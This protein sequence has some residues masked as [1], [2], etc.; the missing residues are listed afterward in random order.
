MKDSFKKWLIAN[1]RP[2]RYAKTIITISNDLKKVGYK[3]FDLYSVSNSHIVK[4]IKKDYFDIEEYFSKNIRGN[5]MYSSAFDRYIEFLSDE[6]S[7]DII[8]Y[9]DEIKEERL[10]E[11]SKKQITVNAYERN[12]KA[13]EKCIKHYGTKCFICSF[14]FEKTY[15][16]IGKGFI[17]V[18]HLKPLSEINEEYT[19]DPIEDLRP[20]CPNCHAMLHKKS[21]AYRIEEV[22][23]FINKKDL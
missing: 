12:P 20:V 7:K 2:E 23:D 1:E 6:T 13:R 21:P 10:T 5:N 3:Y 14:D 19:I 9:P 16:Q 22:Q 4:K 17:H 18:H 15:G 8:I 11:G